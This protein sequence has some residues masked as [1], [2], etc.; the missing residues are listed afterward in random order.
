ME[1]TADMSRPA[2]VIELGG[3]RNRIRICFDNRMQQRI[4]RLDATNVPLRQVPARELAGRHRILKFEDTFLDEIK[5]AGRRGRL[6]QKRCNPSAYKRCAAERGC[7]EKFSASYNVVE[8]K[9]IRALLGH[10]GFS[11]C[12]VSRRNRHKLIVGDRCRKKSGWVIF[13]CGVGA[14]REIN[15]IPPA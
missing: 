12:A 3:D 15:S 7:A 5:T 2:F 11:G 1:R 8:V 13:E 6:P 14:F 4:E 10:N 9:T